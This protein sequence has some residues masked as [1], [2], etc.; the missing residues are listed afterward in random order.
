M[1]LLSSPYMRNTN[2]PRDQ[3]QHHGSPF[4]W[5]LHII[6]A[7]IDSSS[8]KS[9]PMCCTDPFLIQR[10]AH[11]LEDSTATHYSLEVSD[12]LFLTHQQKG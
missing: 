11:P 8:S 3:L 1:L 10:S 7:S 12:P 5:S 6:W 2:V 9:E 4:E